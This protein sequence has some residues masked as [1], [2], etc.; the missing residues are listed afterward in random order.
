MKIAVVVGVRPHFVKLS[1]L[2]PEL[3]ARH[4]VVLVHTGQHYDTSL[5]TDFFKELG[6]PEPDFRFEVGSGSHAQQTARALCAVEEALAVGGVGRAV[7]I[8]DSNT[9]LAGALAAAKLGIPVAHIEA[10]VR[11][12]DPV[13]PE[14]VNRRAIDA[15]SVLHLCGSERARGHLVREGHGDTAVVVGD[16]LLDVLE[17]HRPA[18]RAA[19]EQWRGR[20]ANLAQ[21]VLVTTHRSATMRDPEALRGIVDGVLGLGEPAVFVLHPATVR[22]LEAADLLGRLTGTR[23]ITML[24]AQPHTQLLA[25]ASLAQAVLTDSNGLQREALFLGRACLILRES[26]EFEES[27]DLGAARLVGT[28]AERIAAFRHD[29][30]APPDPEKVRAAFGSGHAA[31][32]IV[33][34]LEA[35]A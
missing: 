5:S 15:V 12:F 23:R 29:R 17:A 27:L 20:L 19:A 30:P 16:L 10:G 7:V 25:L 13:L 31:R 2:Y 34:E 6:L 24:P 35:R 26:T 33:A 18:V 3:S 21:S 1:A 22:A 32:T 14:E 11:S 28:D 8:G 4:E 9:T